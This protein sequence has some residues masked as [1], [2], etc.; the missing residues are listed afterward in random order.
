[1]QFW[2]LTIDEVTSINLIVAIG[3]IV[4]YSAHV[5]HTFLTNRGSRNGQYYGL[6]H[7]E[8]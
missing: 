4:D 3:L 1:M 7:G 2:G 5:A 8:K 6:L